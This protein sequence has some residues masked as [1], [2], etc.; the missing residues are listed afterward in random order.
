MSQK[1]H[2]IEGVVVGAALAVAGFFFLKSDSGKKIVRRV[3]DWRD[4][5]G[6]EETKEK[7][8]EMIAKTLKS[9]EAGFGKIAKNTNSRKDRPVSDIEEHA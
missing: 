6:P 2:F 9:I 3:E 5:G 7:A 8:E 1:S 4:N